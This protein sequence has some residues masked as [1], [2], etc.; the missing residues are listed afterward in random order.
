M[1]K[2]PFT[3]ARDWFRRHPFDAGFLV[4]AA[5]SLAL[6]L[7]IAQGGFPLASRL[8]TREHYYTAEAIGLLHGRLWVPKQALTFECFMDR[9]HCYG[10]FGITPTLLRVPVVTL[11]GPGVKTDITEFAYFTLG[12][13]L[14]AAAAWWLSRQLV[15]LWAAEPAG[16]PFGIAG[17]VA[18]FA[19]LGATPLIFLASRPTVYEEAILW[20]VA[21]A[22]IALAA[23]LSFCRRPRWSMAVVLVVADALGILARPTVGATGLVATGVLA[24]WMLIDA[25]RR[26]T[27]RGAKVVEALRRPALVAVFLIAGAGVAAV[28]A[29][30]VSILKFHT[31]SPPYRDQ[32]LLLGRASR[33]APFTHF[34]GVNGAVIPTHLLSTMLP[35]ALKL[36][37]GRPYVLLGEYRPIAVWPAHRADL[38]WEPTSSV[39]DALPFSLLGLLGGLGVVV[40]AGWR[41]GV[42]RARAARRRDRN[43][44]LEGSALV[45]ASALAALVA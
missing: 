19:G 7:F 26:R 10:Y 23:A 43:P 29:S 40:A 3:A 14:I 35:K 8:K 12:F 42:L 37:A 27:G 36:V 38:V 17:V 39:P 9:G 24:L 6:Y 20:G 4:G 16:R 11:F 34:A 25:G 5:V 33:I 30:A 15:V 1:A 31:V 44:A 45:M 21:F 41:A 32:L 13:C 22:L 28:S 2:P 18:G